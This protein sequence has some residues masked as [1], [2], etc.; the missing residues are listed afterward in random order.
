MVLFTTDG[1]DVDIHAAAARDRTQDRAAGGAEGLA[2]PR[3]ARHRGLLR[4]GM[5][6]RAR[7]L[8]RDARRQCARAFV[9]AARSMGRRGGDVEGCRH[10]RRSTTRAK[11]RARRRRSSAR[12]DRSRAGCGSR[13]VTGRSPSFPP[14]DS[15]WMSAL[16]RTTEVARP[17]IPRRRPP[18]HPQFRAAPGS[19]CRRRS[20]VRSRR[21]LPRFGVRVRT[22]AA[23]LRPRLRTPCA[24][25]A[26][27]RIRDGRDNGGHRAGASRRRLPLCRRPRPRRRQPVEAHRRARASPTSASSSTMRS[28]VVGAMIPA[29]LACR[30]P[31]VLSGSVAQEAPSQ[32]AAAATDIRARACAATRARAAICTSRPTGKTTRTKCSPRSRAEPLLENTA[33]GFAPRPA[34]RPLTKFEA[35]GIGLGHGVWDMLFRRRAAVSA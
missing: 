24:A 8:A 14:R 13:A 35:R 23:R 11:A 26:R 7:R 19:A 2:R 20:N 27:N 34:Y 17:P 10:D 29:R 30:H 15:H 28:Q 5:R 21:L 33:A 16:A 18:P 22:A 32:A 31:R 9:E 3:A 12:L 6:Q 1:D 25:R 4:V